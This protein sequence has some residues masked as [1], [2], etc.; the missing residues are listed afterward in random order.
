M[1]CP[2]NSNDTDDSENAVLKDHTCHAQL[3]KDQL[4]YSHFSATAKSSTGV[5]QLR[6]RVLE[7]T[8]ASISISC[9][10]KASADCIYVWRD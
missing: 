9:W 3:S 6:G 4:M 10:H 5:R 7:G 2:I 8:E 1:P